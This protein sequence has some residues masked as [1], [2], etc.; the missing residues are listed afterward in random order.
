VS[1]P[2]LVIPQLEFHEQ[3]HVYLMDG[4]RIPSVNTV[5]DA[6]AKDWY[7]PWVLREVKKHLIAG[8]KPQITPEIYQALVE[9][10]L[11]V[12]E[13]SSQDAATVGKEAHKW[14]KG[15]IAFRGMTSTV[16]S[17]SGLSK[18]ASEAVQEFLQW[19]KTRHVEYLVS[20]LI[21]AS[22]LHKFAGT[23]DVVVRVNGE[24]GI[25]DF[26]TSAG[27]RKTNYLQTAGYQIIWEEI[28][29]DRRYPIEKRYILL[30]P[31][32]GASFQ[33]HEVPTPFERDKAAFL[34]LRNAWQWM[35]DVK[36]LFPSWP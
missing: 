13:E 31:K 2:G 21:M 32:N 20:E 5:L 1:L 29:V 15:Y 16:P 22:R 12:H 34:A 3:G 11:K 27:I 19:E 36:P 9:N 26:K 18:R 28:D 8:F 24:L 4:H 17:L 25:L 7:T 6:M 33:I 23:P 10:A 35:E 14:I 30:L